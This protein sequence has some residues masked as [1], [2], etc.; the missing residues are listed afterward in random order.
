MLAI[1][2]QNKKT[3]HYL[4]TS[5]ARYL[6][7]ERVRVG[8][9]RKGFQPEYTPLSTAEWRVCRTPAW[10]TQK[11]I[12]AHDDWACFFAFQDEKFVGQLV[13]RPA[14]YSLCKLLDIRVDASARR[15]GVGGELLNACVDWAGKKELKGILAETSDQNPVVCQF[16]QSSRFLLGGVDKLRHY[17][18]PEQA[19]TT[20]ALRDSVL[21]FYRFFR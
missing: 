17:A 1:L 21:S 4:N 7:G 16:L 9:T 6:A 10:L 11:A 2:P 14:M 15:Q 3:L 13:A 18:D 5:D 19:G 20:A 12:L 8:V